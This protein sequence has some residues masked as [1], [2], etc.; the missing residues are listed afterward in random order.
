[1]RTALM[2]VL[3]SACAL[4]L[5]AC[6]AESDSAA[7]SSD[8]PSPS[9]NTTA[10]APASSANQAAASSPKAAATLA[11]DR[12]SLAVQGE[13][14][15]WFL[16][17]NGSARPLPFGTPKADLLASLERVRGPADQGTNEDCPIGPVQY[18]AWAD[19]LTLF[20]Q[21]D[22]FAGWSLDDRAADTITTA[23]GIGGGSTRAELEAAY[24]ATVEQS[25]LGTEFSAGEISGVLD[26]T[27]P[28]ARVTDMWAGISCV[29]R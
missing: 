2:L 21:D 18:A 15:R 11:Q 3:P 14:L 13:G 17:P 9:A 22:R 7:A 16:P 20:F 8:D 10:P 27:G 12:R 4:A 6:A 19:G 29:A 28:A 23:A 26:G 25:T 1:M 24:T 5:A